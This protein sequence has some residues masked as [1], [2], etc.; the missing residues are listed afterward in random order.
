VL[1]G[2]FLEERKV[3]NWEMSTGSRTGVNSVGLSALNALMNQMSKS[4]GRSKNGL[5]Q[6]VPRD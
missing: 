5:E 4:E 1:E 6:K 2:G 3:Q